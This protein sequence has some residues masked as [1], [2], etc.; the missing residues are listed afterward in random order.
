MANM[1]KIRAKSSVHWARI[2]RGNGRTGDHIIAV[3]YD[4]ADKAAKR[5]AAKI[6]AKIRARLGAREKTPGTFG[7]WIDGETLSR[8]TVVTDGPGIAYSGPTKHRC[9]ARYHVTETDDP[10]ARKIAYG[11]SRAK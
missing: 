2:P 1:G 4:P 10:M 5:I 7:V 8:Y 11:D 9:I 3:S 6:V